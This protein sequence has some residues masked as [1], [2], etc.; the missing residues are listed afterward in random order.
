MKTRSALATAF[1]VTGALTAIVWLSAFAPSPGWGGRSAAGDRPA[2]SGDRDSTAPRCL[3][4]RHIGRKHVVDEQTLLVYDD[5]GHAYKLGI[6]GP[7]RN[8]DDWSQI[9]FEFE[10]GDEICNAHDAKI[11]YS[12]FGEQPVTCIINSVKAVTKAEAEALDP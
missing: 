5:F 9:G 1:A 2:A 6:G 7:C 4:S 11:L 12:K 8:M 3:D 10:G